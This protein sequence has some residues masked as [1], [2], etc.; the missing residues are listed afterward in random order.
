LIMRQSVVFLLNLVQD[1]SV[2]RPLAYLARR[3]T[4][5]E[6]IFLVSYQFIER[7]RSRIWQRELA[8]I[9]ADLDSELFVFQTALDAFSVIQN[10]RGFLVA[11][12]E[13]NLPGHAETHDV[14]RIAPAGFTRITLQHGFE[15]VGFLQNREHIIAHGRN[16]T[17]AADI[18]CGWSEAPV[19]SAM[20][21]SERSK[22][23]VTGPSTILQRQGRGKSH[24]GGGGGIVCENLHSVRLRA[25]GDHASSFMD[26][27]HQFCAAFREYGL[28]VTLRPHPGGRYLLTNKAK[29]ADNVIINNLPIYKADLAGY[30]FGISA[31]S[32][33]ILDMLLAGIPTAIWRDEQGVMDIG[34]YEG[35]TEIT[36]LDD[37]L[38]FARDAAYRRDA[39][40]QR[41]QA[42]LD[43]LAMPLDPDDVYQRFAR[44]FGAIDGSTSLKLS[45]QANT[46]VPKRILFI[47][48]GM[49]P[50]LQLSFLTPL[51]EHVDRGELTL[52]FVFEAELPATFGSNIHG[53]EARDWMAAQIKEFGPDLIVCCRYG[54]PHADI[55][56]SMATELNV[57]LLYHA[58][59]DLMNIPRELGERI[60]GART[61]PEWLASVDHL[62]R[63]S[64][65]VYC[66]TPN[67]KRRFR[68]LGYST[69]MIAAEIYCAGEV[70]RRAERK[71]VTKI[72]YMGLDHARGFRRILP[73]LI[74]FLHDNPEIQFELFGSI[75]LPEELQGFGDRI[76]VIEPVS[77][78]PEFLNALAAREWDIGLCP[79]DST[80]FNMIKANTRWVEYTAVGAAV[81]AS[82]DTVY[83]DCCAEECGILVGEHGWSAALEH[84]VRH[85]DARFEMVEKAQER[86]RDRYPVSRLLGQ[87]VDVF[88]QVEALKRS[89]EAEPLLS[90]AGARQE[91]VKQMSSAFRN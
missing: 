72:G 17:F 67:L 61:E 88:G 26:I 24:P 31:P 12:S 64:D 55:I 40:L 5:Y 73:S 68:R 44:L 62:L 1:V 53:A 70:L 90:V 60:F 35:I 74:D 33:V 91:W 29:P 28:P 21:M 54:G 20:P 16:I 83:D 19:L 32:T 77:S 56:S 69:P 75:P 10:R 13:S 80:P 36:S 89:P 57:P 7:D 43:K 22:L 66:S 45:V 2:I 27:F 86:L 3:E 25:T 46:Q 87:V 9:R 52:G 11:G 14:F 65:L 34:N 84:L 41:Q 38:A 71:P 82:K 51:A 49:T 47:A 42:F 58:D 18:L 79:L 50:T 6:I 59:N 76:S 23:L 4:D 30:A 85:P 78:Y 15:C 8:Q 48:D 39:L 81:I 37:W 63:H